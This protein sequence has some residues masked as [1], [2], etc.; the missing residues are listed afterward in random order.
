MGKS[1]SITGMKDGQIKYLNGIF[2]NS[3][4]YYQYIGIRSNV[5]HPTAEQIST[6]SKLF[7]VMRNSR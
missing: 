6:R 7:P 1:G 2:D 3:F 4:F 5:K